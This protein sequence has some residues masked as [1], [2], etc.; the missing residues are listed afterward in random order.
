MGFTEL[1]TALFFGMLV[2]VIIALPIGVLCAFLT[3]LNTY[4]YRKRGGKW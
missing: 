4:T 3:W 2:L 1:L